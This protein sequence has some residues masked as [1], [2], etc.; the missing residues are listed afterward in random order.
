MTKSQK[1]LTSLFIL[2]IFAILFGEDGMIKYFSVE[3]FGIPFIFVS[4]PFLLTYF[5][6]WKRGFIISVL[7][8]GLFLFLV[9]L[10]LGGM[11]AGE[12][13]AF[14]Y[15]TFFALFS[16]GYLILSFILSWMFGS[17]NNLS[18]VR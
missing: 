2:S 9:T 11:E 3:R 10:Y 1:I 6:G 17:K 4:F 7:T 18:I 15:N 5:L 12:G 14:I 16:L 8:S 13:W